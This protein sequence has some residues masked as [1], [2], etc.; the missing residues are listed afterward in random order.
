[1]VGDEYFDSLVREALRLSTELMTS[2]TLRDDEARQI[3][4][5]NISDFLSAQSTEVEERM[6]AYI[7]AN[8]HLSS[9]LVDFAARA[10]NWSA[11]QMVEYVAQHISA[12]T[13]ADEAEH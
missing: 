13:D 11:D 6:T 1:M 4:M 9:F 2:Q 5:Q 7:L 3:S 10:T 12:R 8:A